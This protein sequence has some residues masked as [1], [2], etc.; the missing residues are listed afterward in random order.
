MMK[1]LFC[2]HDLWEIVDEGFSEEGDESKVKENKKRDVSA[3]FLIQQ[4]LHIPL[5][6]CI[7]A[8][9]TAEKSWRTLKAYF[10]GSPKIMAVKIQTLRQDFENLHR[11]ENDGVQAYVSRVN[12]IFNQMRS[13]GDEM[14]EPMAVGKVLKILG[15][16]FNF[17]GAAIG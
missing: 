17:I 6:S 11:R 13:L 16:R 15:P 9:K 4:A 3:L 10:Q 1:T 2:S 5:F 8:A 7:T 14:L 12:D